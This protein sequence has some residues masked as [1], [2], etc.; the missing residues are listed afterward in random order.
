LSLATLLVATLSLAAGSN[1]V[2]KSAIAEKTTATQTLFDPA[3]IASIGFDIG[4]SLHAR[5]TFGIVA[6]DLDLATG[7][8][9]TFARPR[10]RG[11]GSSELRNRPRRSG[12]SRDGAEGKQEFG[13]GTTWRGKCLRER[14]RFRRTRMLGAICDFGFS[15]SGVFAAHGRGN[16]TILD[17]RFNPK[18]AI[19][20]VFQITASASMRPLN[21]RRFR[22]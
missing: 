13:S 22:G 3:P 12:Y 16:Q 17:F 9:A 5:R 21:L 1:P 15:I 11:I 14:C 20:N 4:R 6:E 2:T 19:Q 18:S 7:A 8:I 10:I